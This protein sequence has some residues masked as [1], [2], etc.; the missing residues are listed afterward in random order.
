MTEQ[1]A[2]FTFG[3]WSAP[4][5]PITVEYPLEVMDEIR[6]IAGDGLQKLARG[7][8]DAGGVLFGVRRDSGIRILTWRPI[9][10]EHAFGPALNLSDR[11]RAELERLLETAAGDADLKGLRP[12]GWFVSHTRSGVSLST[13]DLEIFSRCFPGPWQVALVLQPRPGGQARAGFFARHADGALQSDSSYQEFVLRPVHR[14]SLPSEVPAAPAKDGAAVRATR[15]SSTT[16]R[17]AASTGATKWS[18]CSG[19]SP[20][21]R[22]RTRPSA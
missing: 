6:A 1:T 18:R 8:L 4:Q 12:V 19:R 11:D 3:S 2:E 7:G 15:E 13:S 21:S 20:T 17:T 16:P 14:F 10:C 22:E 9:S 5:I